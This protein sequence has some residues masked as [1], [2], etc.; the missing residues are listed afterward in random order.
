MQ[1]FWGTKELAPFWGAEKPLSF[2]AE[3][4]GR[5]AHAEPGKVGRV[6]IH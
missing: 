6:Q 4:Q 1:R 5:T 2:S 3:V